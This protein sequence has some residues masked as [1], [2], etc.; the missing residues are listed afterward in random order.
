[1]DTPDPSPTELPPVN[2]CGC[3][4]DLRKKHD[5]NQREVSAFI[6]RHYKKTGFF[7]AITGAF[8]DQTTMYCHH[9][10]SNGEPG[11]LAAGNKRFGTVAEAWQHL[12]K[13]P[14]TGRF[15]WT[16]GLLKCGGVIEK[17]HDRT[18]TAETCIF[19]ASGL[20]CPTPEWAFK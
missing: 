1:M 13:Q 11:V 18:C 3:T 2:G 10:T 12:G 20:P 7:G 17:D 8:G 5:E 4:F 9:M 14:C 16:G 6:G 15:A 19:V